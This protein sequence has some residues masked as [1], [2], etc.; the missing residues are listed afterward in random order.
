MSATV[1]KNSREKLSETLRQGLR[2]DINRRSLSRVSGL[3]VEQRLPD[4]ICALLAQLERSE[5]GNMR[6]R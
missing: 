6:R 1:M 5:K 2:T 3:D 4:G